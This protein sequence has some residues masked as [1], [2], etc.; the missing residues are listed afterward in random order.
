MFNG[1]E[2]DTICKCIHYGPL[3]LMP[4]EFNVWGGTLICDTFVCPVPL[5]RYSYPHKTDEKTEGQGS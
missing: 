5:G 1:E 2:E 4:E 3:S